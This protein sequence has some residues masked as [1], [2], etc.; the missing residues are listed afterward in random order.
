MQIN[1]TLIAAQQAAREAQANFQAR[2]QAAHAAPKPGFAAALETE[3]GFAPLPL[4]Q[5]APAVPAPL[6]A[7]APLARP[8]SLLDIK[9]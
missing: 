5:T 1:A 3:A 9:V 4:K 2:F 6:P 7:A 8:G